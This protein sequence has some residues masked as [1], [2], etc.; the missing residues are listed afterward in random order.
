[1][2]GAVLSY[3]INYSTFE[4]NSVVDED[5][6]QLVDD[7][8]SGDFSQTELFDY[9]RLQIRDQREGLHLLTGGDLGVAT[10][11][12]RFIT[13]Q[14]VIAAPNDD[15]ETLEDKISRMIRAF[16]VDEA[17]IDSPDTVGASPLTFWTPTNHPPA[18]FRSPVQEYFLCRPAAYPAI[19]ERFKSGM[20]A[21]FAVELVCPDPRRYLVNP[22][23]VEFNATDG[24][25]QTLPNWTKDMG[26]EVYPS[27]RVVTTGNGSD[28]FTISAGGTQTLI[29][30]LSS[31]A[32]AHFTIDCLTGNIERQNGTRQDDWRTSS[33]ATIPFGIPAGGAEWTLGHTTNIDSVTVSFSQA[34]G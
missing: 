10:S 11:V 9:S 17:Q 24:W 32:G 4:L 6:T 25:S 22:T 14:G 7:V 18:G 3:P 5:G 21:R 31:S 33:V 15:P 30:D 19:Y 34:R 23:T 13:L 16:H 27:I 28:K 26:E 20:S 12:F 29:L 1:M 8:Y 2:A